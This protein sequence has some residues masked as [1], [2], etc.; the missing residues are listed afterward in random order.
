MFL[1]ERKMIEILKLLKDNHGASAVKISFETEDLQMT[2]LLRIKD[3]AC[4][5]DLELLVKLGGGEALTDLRNAKLLGANTILGPMIESKFTL[6][7]YLA[8]CSRNYINKG[9]MKFFINI[10]TGP[11]CKNIENII[12]ASNVELLDGVVIGRTDLCR[13]VGA[14]SVNDVALLN[15]CKEVFKVLKS[16]SIRCLLGGGITPKALD[17]MHQLDGVLDGFETRKVVF[18]NYDLTK[19]DL[20]KAI[21][22]ALEFEL[23]WYKYRSKFYLKKSQEDCK[24][25]EDLAELLK[26]T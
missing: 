13:N 10:E 16:K 9:A 19:K 3:I 7:K 21:R 2:E 4:R 24:K 26:T 20:D 6:E 23:L 11:S 22:L 12:S 14:T 18:D 1:L 25:I 8:M 15:H 5:A 17:F